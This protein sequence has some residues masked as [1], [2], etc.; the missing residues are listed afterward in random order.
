MKSIFNPTRVCQLI[1]VVAVLLAAR[2]T[3][4]FLTLLADALVHLLRVL[5][6][7]A[8]AQ[9]GVLLVRDPIRVRQKFQNFGKSVKDLP[10]KLGLLETRN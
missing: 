4:E 8:M 7:A 9:V 6:I 1:I 5:L 3:L 2:D 10:S